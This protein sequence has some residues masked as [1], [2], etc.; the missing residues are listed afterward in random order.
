MAAVALADRTA[1]PILYINHADHLFW[2]GV[3]VSTSS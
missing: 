1:R 2:L 3:G